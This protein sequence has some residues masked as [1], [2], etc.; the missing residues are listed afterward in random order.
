[1]SSLYHDKNYVFQAAEKRTYTDQFFYSTNRNNLRVQ[2]K[3]A[4]PEINENKKS[5][6][7]EKKTVQ[8]VTKV[9]TTASTIITWKQRPCL[10]RPTATFDS[11]IRTLGILISFPMLKLSIGLKLN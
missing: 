9:M 1:M 2:G 7:R 10:L 6:K 3:S 8:W 4:P 11:N 5:Y